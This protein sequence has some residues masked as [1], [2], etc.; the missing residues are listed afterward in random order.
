MSRRDQ[1]TAEAAQYRRLYKSARWQRLR[2]AQLAAEPLCR[3]CDAMGR[4][5]AAVVVDHRQ[6]HRGNERLFFDP[7]NL[8]SLC[9]PHHNSAAQSKDRTGRP[10]VVTDADGWPVEL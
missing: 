8:Q 10:I 1:R 4:V 6:P 3:V 2:E 7:G 9:E 5:T